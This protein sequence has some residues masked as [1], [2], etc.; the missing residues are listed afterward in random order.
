[1]KLSFDQRA[2]KQSLE[3]ADKVLS[4]F[5]DLRAVKSNPREESTVP[6]YFV[7]FE[8]NDK[9]R[10]FNLCLWDNDKV[11]LEFRHPDY[12]PLTV[13]NDPEVKL[14]GSMLWPQ[15]RFRNSNNQI[16]KAVSLIENYTS[17][18]KPA[19]LSGNI[20]ASGSGKAERLLRKRIKA[21]FPNYE[22]L[23]NYRSFDWLQNLELDIV[24]N[25]ISVAIEVQGGQHFAPVWG[26][27]NLKRVQENDAKK[28]NLCR[29]NQV[30]LIRVKDRESMDL[31][32]NEILDL[33]EKASDPLGQVIDLF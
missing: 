2:D 26:D 10:I 24:I 25:D 33:V 1:M 6:N 27:D 30:S 28:A 3:T 14:Y 15:Y 23:H 20:K 29:Q 32:D 7:Y 17:L 8:E 16:K 9:I 19:V 22:I 12:L 5:T 18:I 13:N 31:L 21:L 11:A 4:N